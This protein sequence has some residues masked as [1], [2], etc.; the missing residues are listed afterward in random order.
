MTHRSTR[1]LRRRGSL[2]RVALAAAV[3]FVAPCAVEVPAYAL[4]PPVV[5]GPVPSENPVGPTVPTKQTVATCV[6][7][8]ASRADY[9]SPPAAFNLLGVEKAW[10]FS[11]GAGQRVAVIDTGV[12]RHP[13]LAV[14]GGGDYVSNS[15]GTRDCDGHG[16]Q[17]AGLI[18]AKQSSSDGFAGVAPDASIIAIR[19][20]SAAYAPADSQSKPDG[21]PLTSDGYGDVN[22]LA[23]AVVRAVNLRATVIN[24][25]EGACNT[26]GTDLRDRTLG[27]AVKYAYDRNVVV[28]AAA[29]N[30][31][32]GKEGCGA[33]NPAALGG[34]DADPWASVVTKSSPAYFTPYVVSVGAV[35]DDGR[36]SAFSLAGPWVTVA[37]PGS[38]LASLNIAA[39]PPII[40]GVKAQNGTS[41]ITGTSFAAPFVSGLAALIRA[42]FPQLTAAQVINRITRTAHHPADGR[43]GAVGYG[44]IDP[45]AALTTTTPDVL[46]SGATPADPGTGDTRNVYVAAPVA[47]PATPP[48]PNPVPKNVAI[49]VSVGAIALAAIGWMLIRRRN[50]DRN[51]L[52]EGIDY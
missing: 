3:A 21:T 30:V 18:A 9:I 20:T 15:D 46:A 27:A 6:E 39:N 22:T 5:S 1:A 50:G 47:P 49:G 48:A 38:N 10:E 26:A 25:S 51:Q 34:R 7:T 35:E 32:Q 52:R 28:V 45:V 23:K 14:T 36:P 13:R 17:V 43:D 44:L 40:D 4:T 41:P 8:V 12:F 19:Q 37:A 31:D 29:D 11:K 42:R 33:Q 16:T 24:I 2:G